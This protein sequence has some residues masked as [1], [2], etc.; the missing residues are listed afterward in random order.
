M[1]VFYLNFL[2]VVFALTICD[3]RVPFE[4][5]DVDKILSDNKA[6][7]E[8]LNCLKNVGP[9]TPAQQDFVGK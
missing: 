6:L 7:T 9:C 3:T 2:L 4:S 8:Y 5:E 1:K